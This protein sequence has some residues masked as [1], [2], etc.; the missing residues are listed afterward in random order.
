MGS[1]RQDE[2][3]CQFFDAPESIVQPSAV[4]PNCLESTVWVDHCV[5][6]SYQYDVWVRSPKSVRERRTKFLEWIGSDLDGVHAEDQDGIDCGS[7]ALCR[8]NDRINESTGAVLRNPIFQGEFSC[9]QSSVPSSSADAMG[10]SEEPGSNET[11][12]CTSGNLDHQICDTSTM[13]E[14]R[15]ESNH[16]GLALEQ[17]VV[18]EECEN[19]TGVPGHREIHV[20]GKNQRVLNRVKSRWLD[21]LRSFNC[22]MDSEWRTHYIESYGSIPVPRARA[23]RVKVRHC[24]KRL[25]ELSALFMEQEILAHEGSIL[26]MKFSLDG[27]YLASAGEDNVVRVWQVVADE[28]SNEI[29]IPDLDPSCIYFK[30][31][32]FSQLE[33][34]VTEKDRINKSMGIRKTSESACVVF[35]P[36]I[37]RILE[38]PLHVFLGHN[39]EISD[40]S[41]S[42]NNFLLSSS[43]DKTV[44]LWQVGFDQC[45]QVFSH[46]NF[47]TCVQFNPVND[48]YF[49]SG[50]IDGKVRIWTIDG[51]QVVDWTETRDIVTAVSYRP[52]GQGGIIGSTTGT[53]RFFSVTE[54]HIQLESNICLISKKKSPSKRITGF[55]FVPRDPSKVMVTCADSQVRIISGNNVVTKYKGPRNAGNQILASFTSDGKHIISASDDFNVYMWNCI[56]PEESSLSKPKVKSFEFFSGNASIA[57]PWSGLKVGEPENG[58]LSH[59]VDE[60]RNNALPFSIPLDQELFLEA[61]PKGSATWPEEKLPTSSSQTLPSAMC[62]SQYKFLKN[63]CK[64]TSSSH[65]WSLV[66]V[67]AGEDGRIRSFHNYG[68]PVPL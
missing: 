67:T 33:P 14:H 68:L 41:W 24:K 37:F 34:V 35:P 59:G 55:Q 61:I 4:S 66:I 2:E 60:N 49:I 36:R 29:D 38:K 26:A 53:C 44:R 22:I 42:K 50:S 52:D 57:I 8:E 16:Q 40:L 25:K 6:S 27:Q 5:S 3:D 65:A 48:N 10:S 32:H 17:L 11:F 47:V 45:L 43:I 13:A 58:Q 39:D 23:Q 30:V 18:S 54:N 62:K 19:S 9:S 28:R 7:S 15:M 21:R 64:S 46:S 51:G 56:S 1:F 63:S 31:N 12:L 20:N